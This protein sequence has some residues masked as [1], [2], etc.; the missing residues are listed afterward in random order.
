MER[1][2]IALGQKRTRIAL[3]AVLAVVVLVVLIAILTLYGTDDTDTITIPNAPSDLAATAISTS[4]IDLSW[5]D[6]SDNE[7]G[8]NIERKTGAGGTY[9]EIDTREADV[10]TYS[11]TGLSEDTTYYYRVR[12]YNDAGDSSYSNENNAATLPITIPNAPSDLV[13][14]AISSGQIDLSWRDNSHDE[15]GFKIERKAGAEGSYRQIVTLGA[16]I[17]TYSDVGR[18]DST[19][20][21][22]RMRAYNDA[23][24]SSYSNEDNATTLQPEYHIVGGSAMGLK[25]SVSVMALTKTER[26]YQGWHANPDQYRAPPGTIF[27]V[28]S[29]STSNLGDFPLTVRRIDFILRDS[30]RRDPYA[31]FNYSWGDVGEPFPQNPQ[32]SAG[33]TVTG[34]ILYTV[35]EGAPI[36]GMEV[37]Y[38]LEGTVHIWQP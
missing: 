1:V 34:V 37:V 38:V 23:G 14:I 17:T 11:D 16:D 3:I 33:G 27:V 10:T 5:Q 15:G 7:I 8:F 32:L 4:R 9:S 13:A 19:T 35:P 36:S 6:N 24:H 2:R 22:Y 12:A 28:V 20:Y 25:Q 29:V 31:Q 21:Y 30:A 26:Y 18:I